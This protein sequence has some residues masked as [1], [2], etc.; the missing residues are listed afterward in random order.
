M[1]PGVANPSAAPIV[2][3]KFHHGTDLSSANDLFQNG[4]N[5][6]RAAAWNGSGEFWA[7]VDHLRAVW[8]ANSNPGSPP[9]ACFE[10]EISQG[11]F[12]MILAMRPLVVEL[13]AVGE[14]E[15]LPASFPLLNQHMC[16]KQIVA[17]P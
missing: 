8:F 10:F 14:F 9:A 4:I 13:H 1:E 16:N 17:V 2:S 6:S 11:V 3:I 7:T 15:F 5:Q 12:Q